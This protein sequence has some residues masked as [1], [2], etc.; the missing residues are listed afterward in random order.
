MKKVLAWM[1]CLCLVFSCAGALAQ[2]AANVSNALAFKQNAEALLQKIIQSAAAKL[3]LA[4]AGSDE[5]QVALRNDGQ[6][7]SLGI[8]VPGAGEV[9]ELQTDLETI[10]VSVSGQV[11]QAKL[12]DIIN[13]AQNFASKLF[14]QPSID[15]E[16]A[17]ELVGLF[18]NDVIMPGVKM[19]KNPGN[20][21]VTTISLSLTDKQVM[22][23][24]A[25]FGDQVL[26]TEKYRN[27]VLPALQKELA[28]NGYT[29]NIEEQADEGWA[30]IKEQ[31]LAQES[32]AAL[33]AVLAI[34]ETTGEQGKETA[35][36][37]NA[38]YTENGKAVTLQLTAQDTAALFALQ[39]NV[40]VQGDQAALWTADYRKETRN[41]NAILKLPAVEGEARLTG[42]F[43]EGSCQLNLTALEKNE[44]VFIMDMA[45]IG[46][47]KDAVV[48]TCSITVEEMTTASTF[49]L[50]PTAFNMAIH[51]HEFQMT[52][53]AQK[54]E[55]GAIALAKWTMY[56]EDVNLEAVYDG[57][58][59]I[60]TDGRQQAVI[61][62]EYADE[63]THVVNL[64]L[65]ESRRPE[66]VMQIKLRTALED[67]SITSQLI[68]PDGEAIFTI[69]LAAVELTPIEPLSQ[70]NPLVIT[71]EMMQQILEGMLTAAPFLMQ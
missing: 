64:D 56:G 57:E 31:L 20:P 29:G 42:N 54:N 23:G 44:P 36:E 32:D 16:I 12:E 58:K 11:Y 68:G 63:K 61:T 37:V 3:S 40:A 51:G 2:E 62:A 49:Y 66:Q 4:P 47:D 8:K 43:G 25:L 28:K 9:A 60:F 1:L 5:L 52:L 67:E 59:L 30:E 15:P 27:A 13:V 53:N 33:N 45:A 34:T 35:V 69:Q 14:F 39:G 18:L 50:S 6:V 70:K 24:V 7:L 65:S 10:W 21:S 22:E 71:E 19:E 38:E 48:S 26:G 46:V 41:L 17:Q 55:A